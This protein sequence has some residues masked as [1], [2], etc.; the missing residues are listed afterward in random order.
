MESSFLNLEDAFKTK[1][2]S[3][4][5]T[6]Q[7]SDELR[8]SNQRMME[9]IKTNE[10]NLLELRQ[11]NKQYE[12]RLEKINAQLLSTQRDLQNQKHILAKREGELHHATQTNHQLSR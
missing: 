7:E 5:A 10:Q 6:R 1:E 2:I 9:T 3:E 8:V 11:K 4:V 12:E